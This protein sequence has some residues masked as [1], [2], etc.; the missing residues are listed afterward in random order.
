MN[1]CLVQHLK[2][3]LEATQPSQLAVAFSGGVDSSALLHA[4]S[5]LPAARAMGLRA[6]HVDHGL[7]EES[8]SWARH[9][10]AMCTSWQVPVQI[11]HVD[12]ARDSGLGIEAAARDARYAALAHAMQPGEWLATAQHQDDQAETLLLRLLRGSGTAALGAM[13]STRALGTGTLWRPLLSITRADLRRYADA[14][15]LRWIEDSANANPQFDR[16]W[17]RSEVMPLLTSRWPHANS[18]ISQSAALLADD[19]DL[20]AMQAECALSLCINRTDFTLQTLALLNLGAALRAHVIR[21]WLGEA[22]AEPIPRHLLATIESTLLGEPTDT[23]AEVRYGR[24]IIRRFRDRLYVEPAVPALDREWSAEWDG[25]QALTLPDG[26]ELTIVPIWTGGPLQVSYRQGGERIRLPGRSH[27]H[28]VKNLLQESGIPPWQRSRLPLVWQGDE[29]LAIADLVVSA[30][31]VELHA[32][33]GERIQWRSPRHAF[34]TTQSGP[35]AP[36]EPQFAP[37]SS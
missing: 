10:I 5:Q 31:F 19:G 8:P 36:A 12:V 23:V 2:S 3:A 6:L 32:T 24:V 14:R 17:L 13:R 20:I 9:C 27:R 37:T 26:G 33:T 18:A 22:G 4:L 21:R 34:Q 7:H 28:S 30:R 29:L 15:A 16:S 1:E 11:L 35:N 25:Q